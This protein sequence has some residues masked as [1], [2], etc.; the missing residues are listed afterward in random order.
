[1]PETEDMA[2]AEY[3]RDELLPR[4]EV[5]TFS[6]ETRTSVLLQRGKSSK[7]QLSAFEKELGAVIKLAIGSYEVKVKEVVL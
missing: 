2:I 1:M 6:H 5:S 4:I 7:V 3:L